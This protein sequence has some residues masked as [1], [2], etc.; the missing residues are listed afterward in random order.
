MFLQTT[1]LLHWYMF[2]VGIFLSETS[3]AF[4]AV[5]VPPNHDPFFLTITNVKKHNVSLRTSVTYMCFEEMYN[6]NIYSGCC[7]KQVTVEHSDKP[8]SEK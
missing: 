4:P 7:C 8:K 6:T 1:D 3:A 5:I 2:Q